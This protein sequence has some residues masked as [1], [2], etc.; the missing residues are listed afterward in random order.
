MSQNQNDEEEQQDQTGAAVEQEQ[1]NPNQYYIS[2]LDTYPRQKRNCAKLMDQM[3]Q[4][5]Y[6]D[7][8]KLSEFQIEQQEFE[9]Q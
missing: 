6:A 4:N 1:E 9:A 8:R 2:E 5:I 7:L 3:F